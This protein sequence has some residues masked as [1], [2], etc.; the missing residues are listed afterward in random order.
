[1]VLWL[2]IDRDVDNKDDN[3]ICTK[4]VDWYTVTFVPTVIF[5]LHFEGDWLWCHL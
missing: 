3:V 4:G 1:M 2:A 5:V